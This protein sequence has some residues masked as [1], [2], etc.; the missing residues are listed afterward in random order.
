[1]NW[2]YLKIIT[3]NRIK[4]WFGGGLLEQRIEFLEWNIKNTKMGCGCKQK[5]IFVHEFVHSFSIPISEFPKLMCTQ[6]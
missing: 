5:I 4:N 2:K 6:L 1:M 3:S